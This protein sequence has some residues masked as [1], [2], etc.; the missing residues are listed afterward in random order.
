MMTSRQVSRKSGALNTR[1]NWE[2]I[3]RDSGR[4][5]L[6]RCDT[7]VCGG[8]SFVAY[9]PKTGKR[10]PATPMV[11]LEGLICGMVGLCEVGR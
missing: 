1:W 3:R 6:Q 9:P 8:P 5:V 11:P 10:Q 7:C 2:A 4:D